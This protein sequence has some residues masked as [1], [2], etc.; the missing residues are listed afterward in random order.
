MPK[1]IRSYRDRD[2]RKLSLLSERT[3]AAD[4]WV[5]K[6]QLSEAKF[7]GKRIIGTKIFHK[8]GDWSTT[9]I[10]YLQ[11]Q[12]ELEYLREAGVELELQDLIPR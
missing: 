4:G 8:S 11:A 7:L 1:K 10:G 2:G 9:G 6:L 12:E 5:I 3:I